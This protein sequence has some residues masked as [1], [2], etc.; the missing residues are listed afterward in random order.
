MWVCVNTHPIWDVDCVCY[1]PQHLKILSLTNRF[2]F[3]QEH[4]GPVL[5]LP[6]WEMAEIGS[7]LFP[8]VGRLG[9][10]KATMGPAEGDGSKQPATLFLALVLLVFLIIKIVD[11]HG[12]NKQ[13]RRTQNKSPILPPSTTE[14]PFPRCPNW[15][16]FLI[17]AGVT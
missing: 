16:H 13:K 14:P 4:Y 9:T 2:A 5:C 6:G 17:R 11:A 7:H 3:Q 10:R 1:T 8:R 15:K 12:K